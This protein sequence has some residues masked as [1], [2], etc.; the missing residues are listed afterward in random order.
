MLQL[1]TPPVPKSLPQV[2]WG[3]WALEGMVKMMLSVKG[4]DPLANKYCLGADVAQGLA[5]IVKVSRG[6]IIIQR[7]V[8]SEMSVL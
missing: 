2:N 7:F 8:G 5:H 4:L 1:L 3:L 6:A